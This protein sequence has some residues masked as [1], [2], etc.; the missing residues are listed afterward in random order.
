VA[1]LPSFGEGMPNAVMEAMSHGVAAVATDVAGVREL[2]G[3]GA[4]LIVPP[5]DPA[6]VAEA[7]TKLLDDDELRR[8]SG[9]EGLRV[10]TERHSI[11]SM[12]DAKLAAIREAIAAH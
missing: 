5:G 10:I 9:A 12:R 7:L 4:G 11:P 8:S 2:L 1:V 3:S 6:A